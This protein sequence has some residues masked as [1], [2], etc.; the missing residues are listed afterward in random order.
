MM[1]AIAEDWHEELKDYPSWALQKASRWW[2]SAENEKRRQKPIAGDI[3]ARAKIEMGVVKVAE[4]ALRKFHR[5]GYE[6]PKQPQEPVAETPR[7][8]PSAEQ[9]ARADELVSQFA[10][11]AGISKPAPE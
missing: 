9:K 7:Q 11:R 3:S 1:S 2:M 10:R 5:Y 6:S 8:P 4:S